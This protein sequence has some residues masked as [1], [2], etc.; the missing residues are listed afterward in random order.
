MVIAGRKAGV[1]GRVY[2]KALMLRL[3]WGC[4]RLELSR[5]LGLALV[6]REQ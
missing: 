4:G 2:S 5:V 1:I 3:D 6:M